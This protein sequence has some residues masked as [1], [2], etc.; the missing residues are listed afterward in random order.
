MKKSALDPHQTCLEAVPSKHAHTRISAQPN[1][2][3]G[4]ID[5]QVTGLD[6]A[7]RIINKN[8]SALQ[9]V[10]QRCCYINSLLTP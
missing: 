2:G 4:H 9:R 8:K 5:K 3:M 1:K 10:L 6:T 7:K